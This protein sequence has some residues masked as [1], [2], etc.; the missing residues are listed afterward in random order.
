MLKIKKSIWIISLIALPVLIILGVISFVPGVA[1][2][3]KNHELE[4]RATEVERVRVD[5]LQARAIDILGGKSPE[6]TIDLFITALK[7]NNTFLASK[8]YE[9]PSQLKAISNLQ[10]ELAKNGDLHMSVDYFIEA[11]EKGKKTCSTIGDRCIFRYD[12]GVDHERMISLG[13]NRASGVWKIE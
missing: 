5:Q 12:I 3:L 10:D 1:R 11:M 6:E 9:L 2:W 8:Y 7:A 13:L 4:R